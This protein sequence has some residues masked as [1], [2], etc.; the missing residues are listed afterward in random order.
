[1][2]GTA[3]PGPE[4]VFARCN[5][6]ASRCFLHSSHSPPA[7]VCRPQLHLRCNMPLVAVFT[8]DGGCRVTLAFC[9]VIGLLSHPRLPLSMRAA[10]P[11]NVYM[12]DAGV[13]A[14]DL[15]R[16]VLTDAGVPGV[17]TG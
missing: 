12:V 11:L 15:R 1:M 13:V 5:I 10:L 17:C 3:S 2:G 9:K 16:T 7:T 14:E 4:F 6:P 8:G